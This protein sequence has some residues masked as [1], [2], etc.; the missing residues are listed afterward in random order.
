MSITQTWIDT[1]LTRC[2]AAAL[3]LL[4]EAHGQLY[5]L[6]APQASR[7]ADKIAALLEEIIEVAG[8]IE[9][10]GNKWNG[11]IMGDLAAGIR[12]ATKE[13]NAI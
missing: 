2:S 12:E 9:V 5:G 3:P 13:Y 8:D 10:Y 7:I 11:G 6:A 1:P 4:I